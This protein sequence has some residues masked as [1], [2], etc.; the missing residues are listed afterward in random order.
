[1]PKF[2]REFAGLQ[3]T[4]EDLKE[5]L[6]RL[7]AIAPDKLTVVEKGGLSSSLE[8]IHDLEKIVATWSKFAEAAKKILDAGGEAAESLRARLKQTGEI[9]DPEERHKALVELAA[10]SE[11]KVKNIAVTPNAAAGEDV[12]KKF[13]DG[14]GSP[15]PGIQ[16]TFTSNEGD[17][18]IAR[19]DAQGNVKLPAGSGFVVAGGPGVQ[20]QPTSPTTADG[21]Q[22]QKVAPKSIYIALAS[23]H[24]SDIQGETDQA[25]KAFRDIVVVSASKHSKLDGKVETQPPTKNDAK[26][27]WSYFGW[28]SGAAQPAATDGSGTVLWAKIIPKVVIQPLP[29]NTAEADANSRYDEILRQFRDDLTSGLKESNDPALKVF[30]GKGD[31]VET[32]GRVTGKLQPPPPDDAMEANGSTALLPAA[33]SGPRDPF[34]LSR[35][36]WGR[37]Y[38]DQWAIQRAGFR[39]IGGSEPTAWGASPQKIAFAQ[40]CVVA[41]IGSGV[42]WIHPELATQM[43]RN[44]KEIPGNGEDDDGNGFVDDALGWNF[45]ADSP[46]VMDRGGHDT[47]VAGVI[48]AAWNGLGI[49]GINP[50]ARI[51]ALK[52]ADFRAE[53]DTV[54][55]SR[56]IFYAVDNGARVINISY[57]GVTSRLMQAA[58][59][60]AAAKGVV[61][62]VAAG[63]E[64]DD[65]V[66]HGPANCRNA[67]TVAGVT[68]DDKRVKFSNWGQAVSLAAPAM[69][70]LSLRA[71][72]TDFLLYIADRNPEYKAGTAVVGEDKRLYRASG[73]SF[74]APMVAGTASLLFS[75]RPQLTGE[76]VRRM[77][78]MSADDMETP[79]WDQYTGYGMLNAEKAMAADPDYYQY[80]Q[81]QSVTPVRQGNRLSV[82]VSG[83]AE[84]SEFAGRWLQI[85]FGADPAKD[86]W[87]TVN[88]SEKPVSGGVIGAIPVDA[89]SKPGQWTIR[90]LAQDKRKRVQQSRASINLQP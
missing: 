43:W 21:Q 38:A 54:T 1:M 37:P 77:L 44:D 82:E 20:E 9:K 42:D 89:F 13:V 86:A 80:T 26:G 7:Q 32:P 46:D 73:T 56:A 45:L 61:V 90:V 36:S 52:V 85:G 22:T 60:Y 72:G 27:S 40:P 23:G 66:K 51:M 15:V 67:I 74:A 17:T 4:L 34:F 3:K 59:D 81:I 30:L 62:V 16:I 88:Y 65:T 50:Q 63:N 58:I 68:V 79:G 35:G 2:E 71:S 84:G 83:Q 8:L 47:H 41:V 33:R 24:A 5:E 12:V 49:A 14:G 19:A 6:A 31:T 53:S 11:E 29:G 48:A 28:D 25:N 57:G 10:D 78:L 55:T 87:K 18:Q 70:V 39:P 69:D 76:Q 64:G 75:Q